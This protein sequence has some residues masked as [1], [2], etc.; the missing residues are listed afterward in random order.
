[1]TEPVWMAVARQEIG[2]RQLPGSN[3][4]QRILEY[5]RSCGFNFQHDEGGEWCGCFTAWTM[6]KA[7]FAV[8]GDTPAS[9]MAWAYPPTWRGYGTALPGPTVGAIAVR[10]SGLHV[11][12][13]EKVNGSTISILGGNQDDAVRI[14]TSKAASDYTYRWPQGAPP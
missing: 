8:G 4:N 5:M 9:R 7:G 14:W 1:M 2:Q 3:D 12:F 13:V 11:T 6:L 10:K